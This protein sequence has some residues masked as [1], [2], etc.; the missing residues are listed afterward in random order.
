MRELLY[1]L[2]L[3][4]VYTVTASYTMR[5]GGTARYRE[6]FIFCSTGNQ[7]ALSVENKRS[8]TSMKHIHNACS[9]PTV[10]WIYESN[11]ELQS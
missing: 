4:C 1:S 7:S 11:C 8:E 3:C 10:D 6:S 9:M 2:F 5:R